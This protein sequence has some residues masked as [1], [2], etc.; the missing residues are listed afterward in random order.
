MKNTN[1]SI[2]SPTVFISYAKEDIQIAE[3]IYYKLK[4]DNLKPWLDIHHLTVGVNWS[5]IIQETI[6]KCQ[7]F[8]LLLSNNSMN[9]RGYIQKEIKT[10][11]EIVDLLPTTE[12]FILP[13]KL[14]NCEIPSSLSKY[15]WLDYS[16]P[17]FYTKIKSSI[18]DL[19]GEFYEPPQKV[20]NISAKNDYSYNNAFLKFVENS[21]KFGVCK[22]YN[23]N[24]IGI[25]NYDILEI[26][27]KFPL[28]ST[29]LIKPYK[30]FTFKEFTKVIPS[31]DTYKKDEYVVSKIESKNDWTYLIEAKNGNKCQA[32]PK[33]VDYFVKK[34][35][36]VKMYV[37]S[38]EFT[39]PII[40]EKDG[41]F[42]GMIMPLIWFD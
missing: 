7:F 42:V 38:K 34:Y 33:Y 25:T 28:S 19:L 31:E 17:N 20:K 11:L 37:W 15:H 3:S 1:L 40:C 18:I 32:S 39:Q 26:V 27:D 23:P 13:I 8:M 36:P 35:Y 5:L 30:E 9:K 29:K 6:N 12:I 4:N 14:D 41:Q 16:N 24:K 2:E 22:E 10:A 21:N